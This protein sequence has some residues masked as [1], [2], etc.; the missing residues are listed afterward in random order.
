L[1][2]LAGV[3]LAAAGFGGWAVITVDHLPDYA[4]A[5]QPFDL[6]F[7]VRQHGSTPLEGLRP[8]IEARSGGKE[9]V[10]PAVAGKQAG[11][12]AAKLTIPSTGD[13]TITL[14]SGFGSSRTTL[15]PI[16]VVAVGA[17]PAR[18]VTESDRG[19]R[20]FV[21]K[22]CASCHVHRDVREPVIAD[23]G[24]ELTHKR[25][26]LDYLKRFLAD[27]SIAVSPTA[28]AKMPNL[29]LKPAEIAALAAFINAEGRA[30]TGH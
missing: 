30:A 14:H 2:P 28:T 13:W 19:R 21:A 1:V 24:P 26:Q 8:R 16:E 25:Y 18:I 9:L 3:L 11:R 29:A 10:T 23:V 15:M 6:E 27:P 20:L 5:G 22:G 4:M 7:M 17:Q 12:Y